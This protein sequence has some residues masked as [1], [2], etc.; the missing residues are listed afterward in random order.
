MKNKKWEKWRRASANSL[1]ASKTPLGYYFRKIQS[2][3]GYMAIVAMANKLARIIYVMIKTKQEFDES[4]AKQPEEEMLKKKLLS[5]QRAL[6][7]IQ[8]QLNSAA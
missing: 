3:S 1:K 2:K 4:H 8:K 6:D 5:A 7:R